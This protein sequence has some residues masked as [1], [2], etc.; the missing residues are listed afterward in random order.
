MK[1][2]PP[3]RFLALDGLRGIAALSVLVF[4]MFWNAS[5]AEVLREWLPDAVDVATGLLRSGVAIFFVISGFVIAHTTAEMRRLREGGRFALRRQVRLDPP[6]YAA[7]VLVLVIEFAQSLVP[8][9]VPRTFSPAD[10]LV[11]MVY[12][13]DILGVPAVLAVAWTLCLEVQYYLVVVLLAVVAARCTR[14]DLAR[15]RVVA[16]S[17]TLLTAA[18]L[19]LPLAGL[20]AGPWVIGVWWMFGIGMLLAWYAEGLV[21]T[22]VIVAALGVLVA[23]ALVLRFV[24]QRADPWGSEWFAIATAAFVA[25]VVA[26][27][28]LAQSPGRVL[29][30]AGRLSYS[31][32]LVHLPVISVISGVGFKLFPDQPWAQLLVVL[33][34]GAAAIGC[35]EVLHR[36]VEVPAIRGSKRLKPPRAE[37]MPSESAPATPPS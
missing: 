30:H 21:G 10:V 13:Q 28:R 11:N 27:G 1:P 3:G 23:W 9:L 12:L 29:L 17:A 26:R 18:S 14:S 24:V 25:V 35:A 32:Y 19:A 6:Y 15:R 33:V 2:P 22:R 31:L 34:A 20:S 7:I 16:V 8:G 4:H 36:W 37:R 5:G